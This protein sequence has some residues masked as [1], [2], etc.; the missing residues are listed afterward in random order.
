MAAHKRH[1]APSVTFWPVNPTTLSTLSTLS[2]PVMCMPCSAWPSS[3]ATA[4]AATSTSTRRCSAP[5]ARSTGTPSGRSNRG[6]PAYVRI[7][8]ARYEPT[9]VS[10]PG[11]ISTRF[12]PA[13]A[14]PTLAVDA[15]GPMLLVA[16]VRALFVERLAVACAATCDIHTYAA[17]AALFGVWEAHA[18]ARSAPLLPCRPR[19]EPN[20]KRRQ[21][22][23]A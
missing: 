2:A 14:M 23:A 12:M 4:A 8:C 3:S 13:S 11:T 6:D 15:A 5:I 18:L 22:A 10:A 16:H 20:P 7:P 19:L 17:L 1:C 21:H 9:S